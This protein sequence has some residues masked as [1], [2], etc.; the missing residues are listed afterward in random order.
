MFIVESALSLSSWFTGTPLKYLETNNF[1]YY[2]TGLRSQLAGGNQ[3][4]I[5]KRGRGFELRTTEN[6]SSKW[7]ERDLN[8]GPPDC[9]QSN[10]LATRPRCLLKVY[11]ASSFIQL[12]ELKLSL[13]L[14][15]YASHFQD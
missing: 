5:Y 13:Q 6:K 12:L 3:L 9:D 2:K 15:F 4:A 1:K 8:P 10:A 14:L 7:P 11:S